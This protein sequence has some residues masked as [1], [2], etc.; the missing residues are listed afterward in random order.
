MSLKWILLASLCVN[1]LLGWQ[2][3]Q[4]SQTNQAKLSELDMLKTHTL[5]LEKQIVELQETLNSKDK[6]EVDEL[7]ENTSENIKSLWRSVIEDVE[8]KIENLDEEI[9]KF[10]ENTEQEENTQNKQRT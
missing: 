10:K 3:Y 1:G 9:D 7:I 8:K 6:N 2:L 5:A 4:I